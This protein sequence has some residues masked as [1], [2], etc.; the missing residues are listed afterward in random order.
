[1]LLS[2]SIMH[3]WPWG[4]SCYSSSSFTTS[5]LS[6]R[7]SVFICH[8]SV[9]PQ[10]KHSVRPRNVFSTYLFMCDVNSWFPLWGRCWCL[11]LTNTNVGLS[12]YHSLDVLLSEW[13]EREP[14]DGTP[15]HFWQLNPACGGRPGKFGD[16]SGFFNKKKLLFHPINLSPPLLCIHY[17]FSHKQTS[18]LWQICD[19][20]PEA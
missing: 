20:D 9:C 16:I 11:T 14:R 17:Q 12:E 1:M 19:C 10:G 2:S 3:P 7:Y 15:S 4:T 13:D 5:H 18:P 6:S 8:L